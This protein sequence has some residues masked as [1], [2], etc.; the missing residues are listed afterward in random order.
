MGRKIL[1]FFF[2]SFIHVFFNACGADPEQTASP[3]ISPGVGAQFYKIVAVNISCAASNAIIHYTTDGS[4]PVGDTNG[5]ACTNSVPFV[6]SLSNTTELK[7]FAVA[8][9][10]NPSEV[11]SASFE[12]LPIL[13]PVITQGDTDF[14]GN[15][16]VTITNAIPDVQLCYTLDGSDP[17][18]APDSLTVTTNSP[19][20][21]ILTNTATLKV[22]ALS[23]N[24]IS[25]GVVSAVF[26]KKPLAMPTITPGS[27]ANRIY[28]G[29]QTVTITTISEG[30]TILYTLDNT[31]PRTNSSTAL[32]GTSNTSAA[33]F[34][35]FGTTTVKA[36]AIKYGATNTSTTAC[37]YIIVRLALPRTGQTTSYTNGDD[38]DLQK[39][40]DWPSTRFTDNGD[41]TL[42][43]NLTGLMWVRDMTL[44]TS[45]DPGFDTDETA[46]DG[47]VTWFRALDY[48]AKL[49]AE[50]Y[51]GHNDWRMANVREMASLINC[52]QTFQYDWLADIGFTNVQTAPFCSTTDQANTDQPFLFS[53]QWENNY[54]SVSCKKTNC[55]TF[56]VVRSAGSG[57]VA[58]P[59]TGQTTS[60]TNG[61]DGSV[62]TGQADPSPRFT[63]NGNGTITDNL[64]GLMWQQVASTSPFF[65]T[66]PEAITAC[67]DLSLAG[68]TDWRLPNFQ[69][70]F[71]LANYGY[72]IGS[73]LN[74]RGFTV[75]TSGGWPY[76]TSTTS[77]NYTN[78]C[79]GVYFGDGTFNTPG[80]ANSGWYLAVRS[81][82]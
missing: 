21:L 17:R 67:S 74:S 4:D 65:V 71:S 19:A 50:N 12:Q 40:V 52:T 1:I 76:L 35:V 46:D 44:M 38:G 66:W 77:G 14:Y 51:A 20:T 45:R 13:D 3:V 60:Y 33:S 57:S 64:T 5:T 26:T 23:A 68:Y 34:T 32:S 61:D 78:N 8:E 9:G 24:M 73:W 11:V 7:V 22:Y 56:L 72:G 69:E 6:L 31:D 41:G 25:S 54:S 59:V 30:A 43:D 75:Q 2:I 18:T 81:G 37:E 70:L 48:A 58:L 47:K 80:K 42:T 39:G 53:F 15:I 79:L 28:S 27:G 10:K 82:Q 36:C 63:D 16:E 55:R 62:Q 29:Q 49:A